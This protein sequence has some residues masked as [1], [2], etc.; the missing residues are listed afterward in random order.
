MALYTVDGRPYLQLPTWERHQS[1]RAKSSKYPA[2]EQTQADE[3]ICKQEQADVPVFVFENPIRESESEC[4]NAREARHAHGQ[5]GW[6]KLTDAQYAKLKADLGDAE[7]ERCIA[8]IDESAQSTGN[9]NKWKDWNLTVRKCSR[10]GW[11]LGKRPMSAA[12]YS[13]RPQKAID[14][15]ELRKAANKI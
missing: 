14:M 13:A 15:G 7:V 6:V 3:S 12:E 11:G 8:Y 9:K 10:D 5:Y 4:E 2:C 1:I